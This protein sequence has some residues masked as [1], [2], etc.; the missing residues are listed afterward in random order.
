MKNG[1]WTLFVAPCNETG[2][3]PNPD[4]SHL[5]RIKCRIRWL[6]LTIS[7]AV[8]WLPL[9]LLFLCFSPLH[10]FRAPFASWAHCL[11]PLLNPLK[12]QNSATTQPTNTRP[13]ARLCSLLSCPRRTFFSL[14]AWTSR[15]QRALLRPA[16]KRKVLCLP[17]PRFRKRG[18]EEKRSSLPSGA[19]R[20]GFPVQRALSSRR[21][22]ELP[23]YLYPRSK[24]STCGP[25]SDDVGTGGSASCCAGAGAPRFSS[26]RATAGH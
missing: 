15:V 8:S 16:W 1:S 26:R 4:E 3:S 10:S 18:S 24:G 7:P 20:G 14:F 12:T 11:K 23:A 13:R 22:S 21:S 9:R 19:T 25:F 17:R 6:T 5:R 2:D